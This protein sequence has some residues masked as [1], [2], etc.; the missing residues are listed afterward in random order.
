MA[1]RMSAEI[2]IGGKFRRSW[3]DEFPVSDLRL[4]WDAAALPSISETGT[5][6]G[7][8]SIA[9]WRK[10]FPRICRH[11]LLSQSLMVNR[12]IITHR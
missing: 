7:R 6:N 4:D 10:S 5:R 11:C 3:I 1:D 9:D 12:E 2:L 8:S